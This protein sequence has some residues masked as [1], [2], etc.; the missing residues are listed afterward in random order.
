MGQ[1]NKIAA[2]LAGTALITTGL[3]PA[4]GQDAGVGEP[5][6]GLSMTLG[7]SSTLRFND[8]LSL[9]DP[10]PGDTTL[11]D[12]TVNFG[13]ISDT[14]VAQFSLDLGAT[15]RTASVP[16]QDTETEIDEP[17]IRL[18]YHLESPDTLLDAELRY[19]RV[20]LDFEDPLAGID[21]LIDAGL[22][23]G[24]LDPS[25]GKRAR[26]NAA[27]S[28]E[29]GRTRPFGFGTVLEYDKTEYWDTTDPGNYDEETTAAEV[30]ARL[31][32]SPVMESRIAVD[33]EQYDAQDAANT[34][35][36][37]WGVTASLTYEIDPITRT[38]ASIGYT[39]VD[40][41]S[42]LGSSLED[43]V[44]GGLSVTRDIP[45]G[46]V[47]AALSTDINTTGRRDT[48]EVL[49]DFE[50]PSGFI[51][52]SLGATRLNQGDVNVIGS[53][54]Y[55]HEL[56]LGTVF[57]ATLDRTYDATDAGV[58]SRSTRA[59]LGLDTE[60]TRSASVGL[61]LDYAEVTDVVADTKTAVSG[62]RATYTHE[63]TP[64]WDVLAGYEYRKREET[65]GTDRESNELFLTVTRE[66]SIR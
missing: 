33:W 4:I 59:S 25:D 2:L 5:A 17:S 50:T 29:T 45:T 10:S 21:D 24:D 32:F 31:Q 49:G 28:F 61:E 36:E 11:W 62:L 26:Y 20:S 54:G 64:D 15:A 3:L 27:L 19:R 16:G 8:N 43:G 9:S 56:T 66:F 57:T 34:T 60:L 58:E 63:L 48:F 39:E 23:P 14:D 12:N 13:L 53:L 65:G 7:V 35:R 22:E 55:S 41:R 6:G 1:K 51:N 47:T 18:G 37:T 42:L 44:T 30:F 38:T 40:E 46:S 52:A